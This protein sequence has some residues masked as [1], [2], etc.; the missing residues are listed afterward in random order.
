MNS[1][2]FKVVIDI[3]KNINS[4]IFHMFPIFNERLNEYYAY[5]DYFPISHF[6]VLSKSDYLD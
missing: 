1:F 5:D 2:K 4:D 6:R 3:I